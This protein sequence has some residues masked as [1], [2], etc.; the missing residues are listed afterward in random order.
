MYANN[1]LPYD[2]QVDCE[3]LLTGD[4]VIDTIQVSFIAGE[5]T[6]DDPTGPDAYQYWAYDM[7]DVLYTECPTYGW[8]ELDPNYGG[9]GT[10]LVLGD[11][12]TQQLA[13]P[14]SF[15]YYGTTYDTISVCSNGWI[16]LGVTNETDYRYYSPPDPLGPSAAVAVFWGSLDPSAAG[17]VYYQYDTGLHA[18]IVEWSR[19]DHK[20][21]TGIETF[22]VLLYDPV[23]NPTV[24]GDGEIFCQY[25]DANYMIN[26]MT[27]IENESETDGL[28]YQ[29]SDSYEPGSS[30]ITDAFVCKFTTDPPQYVVGVSE[31][32]RP[33]LPRIF[34]LSQSYPNPCAGHAFI[35][36]QLPRASEVSLR[37]YDALGRE[38]CG[39]AQGITEP[40][41]YT[42]HWDG[43]D[44]QGRQ[45]PSGVYFVK[46]EAGT[47]KTVQK[48]I[49]LK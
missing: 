48:T 31:N 44:G 36:Y 43:R 15:M 6:D 10:E 9:S 23:Y 26:S 24:T 49:L 4:N 35:N 20:V 42:V 19:V 8:V 27:A 40:G 14:F 17:G 21:T 28:L 12:E 7:T 46:F 38:V 1:S 41:Y 3:L 45:V 33:V 2:H 37:V 30:P 47:Y 18:F 16:A 32:D 39:L 25:L 11:D 13:L 22:E 29:I 5:R 34:G